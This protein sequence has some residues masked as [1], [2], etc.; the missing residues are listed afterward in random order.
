MTIELQPEVEA[1]LRER[2]ERDGYTS[3]AQLLEAML[4][5]TSDSD[6]REGRG[7][8]D[9]AQFLLDSPLPGSGLVLERAKDYP[10]PVEL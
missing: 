1:L 6:V 2:M 3:V 4:R 8:A 7:K 5:S 10:R 9:F